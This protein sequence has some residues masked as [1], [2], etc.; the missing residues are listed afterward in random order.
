MT[1]NIALYLQADSSMAAYD[2]FIFSSVGRP[3]DANKADALA[4]SAVNACEVASRDR[5]VNQFTRDY[6]CTQA[7]NFRAIL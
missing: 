5:S 2:A 6:Y 7:A 4:A 3:F 1:K